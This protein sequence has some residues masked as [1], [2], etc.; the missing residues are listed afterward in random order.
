MPFSYFD[1]DLTGEQIGAAIDAI[2]GVI[3][4]SNNGKILTVEDGQIVAKSV[5]EW[6]SGVNVIPQTF[7]EN[8]TFSAPAGQAYSPVTVNVTGV[9]GSDINAIDNCYFGPGVINQ[10]GK[11]SYSL[12]AGDYGIDR[13]KCAVGPIGMVV[14]STGVTITAGAADSSIMQVITLPLAAFAGRAVTYSLLYAGGFA[15]GTAIIPASAA[16]SD[17]E[18][19][20]LSGIPNGANCRLKSSGGNL[21]AEIGQTAGNSLTI[22]A[23]K[24]ELGETQSLA[25]LEGST[26]VLNEL[27]DP[28]TELAKCKRYYQRLEQTGASIG[29][30]I[31]NIM[32]YNDSNCNLTLPLGM[33]PASGNSVTVTYSNISDIVLATTRID[34]GI[35]ADRI[36]SARVTNSGAVVMNLGRTDAL[37]AGTVYNAALKNNGAW[38]AFSTEP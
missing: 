33:R 24:L 11:S 12:S 4:P 13:W 22:I 31:A 36:N 28:A 9:G 32:A 21:C 25:H 17:T 27:P 5:S 6:T 19:I 14:G 8:G 1:S 20:T 34:Q 29:Y 35:E 10:R 37:T 30:V 2:H 7:T 18:I 38:L 3:D 16:S 23:V 26:W 15:T